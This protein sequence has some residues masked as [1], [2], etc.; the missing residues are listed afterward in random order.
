MFGVY[1]EQREIGAPRTDL[2]WAV[3]NER[4]E[5]R[6]VRDRIVDRVLPRLCY[7]D[8]HAR[9]CSA[10]SPYACNCLVAYFAKSARRC[11][12]ARTS[13]L[14]T[15][16]VANKSD[17]GALLCK[18][19]SAR[20]RYPRFAGSAE[21]CAANRDGSD[22]RRHTELSCERTRGNGRVCLREHAGQRRDLGRGNRAV[23]EPLGE[24]ATEIRLTT[25]KQVRHAAL[26]TV[27][28]RRWA[29]YNNRNES[30]KQGVGAT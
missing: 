12:D 9:T 20:N 22:R 13:W 30:F 23:F 27:H 26:A 17:F 5:F 28:N 3:D 7:D 19:R 15:V 2:E 29:A 25:V 18:E 11:D 1:C 21:R 8:H 6:I 24:Q 16:R 4:V 14:C 10:K